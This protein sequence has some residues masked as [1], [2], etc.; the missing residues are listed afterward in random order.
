MLHG[1]QN[2]ALSLELVVF[3]ALFTFHI[4][5]GT[6]HKSKGIFTGTFSQPQWS[7]AVNEN[8]WLSK[9]PETGLLTYLLTY[10]PHTAQSSLR[11]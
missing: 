1:T 11:S 5:N 8:D 2:N 7:A 4:R 6:M 10:L 3:V 9:L